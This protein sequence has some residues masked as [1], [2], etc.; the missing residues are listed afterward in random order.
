MLGLGDIVFYGV[1]AGRAALFDYFTVL[2]CALGILMVSSVAPT[3]SVFLL[4]YRCFSCF[5]ATFVFLGVC[6]HANSR[7]VLIALL[8]SCCFAG[9]GAD[10]SAHNA[11]QRQ[12]DARA[13]SVDFPGPRFLRV[14]PDCRAANVL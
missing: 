9:T 1:L 13:A 5:C 3:L 10:N 14:E 7:A 8:C 12:G 4:L 11:H 6:F 2:S